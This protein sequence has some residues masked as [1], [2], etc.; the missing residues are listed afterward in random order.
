MALFNETDSREIPEGAALVPGTRPERPRP[1]PSTET[2]LPP[3]AGWG[4]TLTGTDGPRYWD[5]VIL[6]EGARYNRYKRPAT[7]V[8][9]EIT[10]LDSLARH[11]GPEVAQRTLVV[12]ARRLAKEVRPCDH[13]ARIEPARFGIVLTE[14]NEIAAINFVER[15]RAACEREV[16]VASELVGVAFG[17]ASPPAKGSL[18]D[19]LGLAG[20]R[21]ETEIRGNS[22]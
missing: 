17:W 13:I 15:V 21:L 4:D 12:A 20:Q 3:P 9:V 18:A 1:I 14:T 6:S 10:G 16:R 5:R 19:A 8:L 2:S 11:W 7:I 22:G